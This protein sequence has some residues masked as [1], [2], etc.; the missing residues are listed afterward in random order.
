L[1]AQLDLVEP[2]QWGSFHQFGERYCA[3]YKDDYGWK[4]DGISNEIELLERLDWSRYKTDQQ[5]IAETLPAKRRQVVY[6]SRD[7]QNNPSGFANAIKAA[8]FQK[9]M[10]FEVMLAE[11]ASR[12]R[13]YVLERVMT[14]LKSGQKVVVFTGRRKDC[15]ILG[16]KVKRQVKSAKLNVPV[17]CAHGGTSSEER[18]TIRHKYM[19]VEGAACLVGT[20][21]AWG[22]SVNL[23]DTD[24]ALFVMLPWTP[25]SIAQWE[26]RF[27]RLG[28]KRPVLISYIIAEGTID[29]H[30]ADVLLDKL[31]AVGKIA[32]D[33]E[34]DKVE[35]AFE[36]DKAGLLDRVTNF[37]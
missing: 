6:L 30:V 9:D 8:K 7:E 24:L 31:P 23:Q 3:G 34:I 19:T 25:R 32:E 33:T 29:E 36:G 13:D 35:A 1:W 18:D 27:A 16:D 21:D 14:A 4:Y 26:G 10:L 28:Q 2:W 5:A 20:G 12:K 37:I 15:D 17:F 11:A 22:E